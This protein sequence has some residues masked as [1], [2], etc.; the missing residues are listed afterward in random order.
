MG[1]KPLFARVL[2]ERQK[3]QKIGSIHL[4]SSASKRHAKATGKVIAV[5]PTADESIKPGMTV[6]FGRHAGDWLDTHYGLSEEEEAS[7]YICQDEDILG[8]VDDG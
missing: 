4:P 1:F 7:F 3:A 8:V 2:L 5:G 6:L